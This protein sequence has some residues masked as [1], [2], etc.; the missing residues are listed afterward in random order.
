MS[1]AIVSTDGISN[2]AALVPAEASG[3]QKH[4]LAYF[5]AWLDTH[6]GQWTKPNLEAYRNYL[7]TDYA[8]RNGKP[9]APSSVSS[10]LSTIRGRYQKLMTD[11]GVRDALYRAAVDGKSIADKKAL[12]D[13]RLIRIANAID[14]AA[15]AVTVVKAQ[16]TPDERHLRLTRAHANTLMT[17]PER[18]KDNTSLMML[19]DTALIV[20][21]LCTGLR[22]MELCGLDVADLRQHYG[23]ELALNVRR[24]KGAK[25]RMIPYGDLDWCL[26]Y[27]D[28]WLNTAGIT[29]GAVFRGFWRGSKK[30]ETSTKAQRVR[31]TRLTVRAVNQIF[32]RYPITINGQPT[33]VRPHDCRRTYARRSWEEGTKVEVIQQNLG[34]ADSKTTLGYIGAFDGQQRR[35]PALYDQPDLQALRQRAGLF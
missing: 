27:V 22:E 30:K 4:R 16:D 28:T 13:E 17:A 19:R 35:T 32:D 18:R 6:G 9:L 2:H 14:P 26:V 10:H 21:A 5:A 23:G 33:I 34:H 11:N 25:A 3:H 1:N 20:L 12:V 31:S 15:A 7:L 29:E 24:G 8:G